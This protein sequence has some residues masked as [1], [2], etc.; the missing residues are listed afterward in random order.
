MTLPKRLAE[1]LHLR[2]G[3]VLQLTET[4]QGLVLRPHRFASENLAPL[5]AL[6]DPTLPSPDFEQIRAAAHGPRLRD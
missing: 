3:A 5:R 2:K 4:P 6:I 1:R